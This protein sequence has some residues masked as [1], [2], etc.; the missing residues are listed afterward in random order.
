MIKA[1]DLTR[2]YGKRMGVERVSF[3]VKKG[4]IAGL[5]GPNGAGKS[6][7]MKMLSGYQLPTCG[8]VEIDGK[9][10]LELM[11]EGFTGVGFLPENPPLYLDME[12]AEMLMFTASIKKIPKGRRR[13]HVD[14]IMELTQISHVRDRLVRNLS[15]GYRQRVGMAQA[16]IGL[17]EVIILDEPTVGMDPAQISEVRMMLRSLKKDHAMIVSSHILSEIAEVC[18][19][20]LIVNQGKLVLEDTLENL[21]NGRVDQDRFFLSTTAG[22]EELK[23]QLAI[24]SGIKEIV[25]VREHLFQIEAPDGDELRSMVAKRLIET[26]IP[27]MEIRRS[28]LSLEEMFLK[29]TNEA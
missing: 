19:K 3:T 18:D 16:L 2:Y 9:D 4:E 14:D 21:K 22:R 20:I 24:F 27:V 10:I 1:V 13:S 5:L 29:L 25:E 26:G 11:D 8:T 12:V 7:I 17:P 15:K 23:H 28:G 6:T